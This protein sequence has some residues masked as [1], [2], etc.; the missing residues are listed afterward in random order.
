MATMA[1][2]F[3]AQRR[4]LLVSILGLC[5]IMRR[6]LTAMFPWLR[7]RRGLPSLSG[8]AL[9]GVCRHQASLRIMSFNLRYD[10]SGDV[11]SGYGW[12]QRR[13]SVARVIV[14]ESADIV[15]TQ[16]G[17]SNQ[18]RQLKSD[19]RDQGDNYSFYGS[20]RDLWLKWFPTGEHCAI[21]A[22]DSSVECL[23]DYT[24][25]LSE[26]PDC[27]GSK[28]WGTACPR[29]AT[30]GW[31]RLKGVSQDSGSG[32][33]V[34]VLNT[35]LDHMSGEARKEGAKLIVR[36][37][38]E[39][40]IKGPPLDRCRHVGTIVTGDFNCWQRE[41]DGTCGEAFS[42]FSNA[43]FQDACTQGGRCDALPFL[44]FHDW[45]AEAEA[46]QLGVQDDSLKRVGVKHGHIDWILWRGS[47][48]RFRSFEV[49]T[50]RG[51]AEDMPPPSDHFP[52]IAEFEIC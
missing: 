1:S 35:H 52:V 40:E 11:R 28:S 10:N 41:V 32:V 5:M 20:A 8:Q 49:V 33:C 7:S 27:L 6:H 42:V 46:S 16:E 17:L 19:L 34:L 2:R 31:Y 39:L 21:F 43:G 45:N 25:A 38:A 37:L 4:S 24:F 18:L 9:Q 30:Y 12:V 22:R 3:A 13:D 15:G 51:L 44:T 36:Q 26:R 14:E 48:M 47:G 50:A 29:I 23:S